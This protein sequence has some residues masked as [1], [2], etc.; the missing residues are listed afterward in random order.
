MLHNPQNDL[1]TIYSVDNL[2][3]WLETRDPNEKFS[4]TDNHDCM[5]HRYFTAM[6]LSVLRVEPDCYQLSSDPK[7]D[8]PY[9]AELNLIAIFGDGTVEKSL[10]LAYKVKN[11]PNWTLKK[12]LRSIILV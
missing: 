6:G 7:K 8:I 3:A 2:I 9:P 4:Y 12:M 5:I 1:R 10:L 11:N